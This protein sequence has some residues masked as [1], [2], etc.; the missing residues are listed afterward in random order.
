MPHVLER[1]P[2]S[3]ELV[4]ATNYEAHP[5]MYYLDSRVIVGLSLNNI[6]R[7]RALAV[8]S[9]GQGNY[10]QSLVYRYLDNLVLP[11]GFPEWPEV[12]P[13][14]TVEEL[15]DTVR[16]DKAPRMEGRLMHMIITP[17]RD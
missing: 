6:A 3:R 8:V 10:Y 17:K 16:V 4:I 15:G 13:E 11:D 1:Y 12:V 9:G 5:L 2:D 14:H 7:E